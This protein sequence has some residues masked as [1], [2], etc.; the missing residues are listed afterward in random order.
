LWDEI[1]ER[2][3]DNVLYR[4]FTT[5]CWKTKDADAAR[6][7]FSRIKDGRFAANDTDCSQLIIVL[8]EHKEV[9]DA[10]KIF[11]W[12]VQRNLPTPSPVLCP[13]LAVCADVTALHLGERVHEHAKTQKQTHEIPVINAL[14]HMYAKCGQ[15]DKSRAV[16]EE[17]SA[18]KAP[19]NQTTWTSIMGAYGFDGNAT[20]VFNLFQR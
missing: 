10:F 12:M 6:K 16:F 7:L 11:D 20:E 8:A 19:L 9:D 5:A 18:R 15:T 14:I 3:E 1:N 13:L 4:T 17:A 2:E